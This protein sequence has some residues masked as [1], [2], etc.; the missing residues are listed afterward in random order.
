MGFFD[1]KL[2]ATIDVWKDT[3]KDLVSQD[4]QAISTTAIDASAPYVNLGELENAGFDL[5]LNY[6]DVTSNG[7]QY[8]ISGNFTRAKNE[9]T[10][11]ISPFYTGG[12]SRVGPMTRTEVGQPISFFYGRKVLGIF[13]TQA[14]VAA[15]AQPDA[16]PGRFIYDDLNNDGVIN[17]E[18]RQKIGDPHPCLL[19]TSP[20]P[21]D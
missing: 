8:S 16:A 15:S 4:T 1:N 6:S 10:S 21:R 20:S 12:G 2:T 11:L 13:Q 14:E 9:I 5:S 3:T 17:D 18:D 7:L 19:Y